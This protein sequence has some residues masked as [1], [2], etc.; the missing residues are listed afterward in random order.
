MV[1]MGTTYPGDLLTRG[2]WGG[3]HW[4]GLLHERRRRDS[5]S[6]AKTPNPNKSDVISRRRGEDRGPCDGSALEEGGAGR[7]GAMRWIW[8]GG[9]G[10]ARSGASGGGG[11]RGTGGGPRERRVGARGTMSRGGNERSGWCREVPVA[12]R[13][14]HRV[15]VDVYA[16]FLRNSRDISIWAKL[17]LGALLTLGAWAA[18]YPAYP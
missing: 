11:Y 10:N 7:T 5:E 18:V 16:T 6:T 4:E 1:G 2:G 15:A 9:G 12:G 17:G 3:E 13:T 8:L 14:V